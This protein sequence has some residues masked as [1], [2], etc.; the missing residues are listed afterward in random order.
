PENCIATYEPQ[1][2]CVVYST[3]DRASVRV[4]EEVLQTL[5]RSDLVS[6]RAVIL[7]GNKVDLVRSRSVATEG[8]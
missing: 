8:T 4:A 6:A 7:V 1:A 5:W 2:Y 3:T